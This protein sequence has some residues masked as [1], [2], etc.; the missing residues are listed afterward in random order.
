MESSISGL[1]TGTKPLL[2]SFVLS[3]AKEGSLNH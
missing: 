2:F 3:A 1:R